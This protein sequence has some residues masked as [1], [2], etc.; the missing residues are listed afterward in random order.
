[1]DGQQNSLSYLFVNGLRDGGLYF[2]EDLGTSF[3]TEYGATR[4]MQAMGL[5]TVEAI[6]DIVTA[7]LLGPREHWV[8]SR[9]T[10]AILPSLAFVD[11]GPEICVFGKTT[12]HAAFSHTRRECLNRTEFPSLKPGATYVIK[13]DGC[14]AKSAVR[15]IRGLVGALHFVANAASGFGRTEEDYETAS[16]KAQSVRCEQYSCSI[17]TR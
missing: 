1:M 8:R 6:K 16:V 5:T 15:R 9:R 11:C 17:I 10:A 14:L 13:N 4:D 12:R 7:L 2:L 3:D